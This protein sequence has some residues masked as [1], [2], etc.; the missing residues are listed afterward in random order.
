MI[1][2]VSVVLRRTVCD[3]IDW[4]FDNVSGSQHQSPSQEKKK[5][6]RN[7]S[8]TESEMEVILTV[9]V[10]VNYQLANSNKNGRKKNEFV[11]PPVV[12]SNEYAM[13]SLN[14]FL[15][16]SK[17]IFQGPVAIWT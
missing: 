2:R 13:V 10:L 1:V 6:K 11:V 9:D 12:L 7:I 17:A 4:R 16:V 5:R 8:K 15:A 14:K 3:D